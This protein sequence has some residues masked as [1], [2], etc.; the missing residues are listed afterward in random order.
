[1]FK[2]KNALSFYRS[3]SFWVS[4]KSI[5]SGPNDFGHVQIRFLLTNFYY[6]DLFSNA[7]SLYGSKMILNKKEGPILYHLVLQAPQLK[8]GGVHVAGVVPVHGLMPLP[9]MQASD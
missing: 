7:L 4:S 2:R 3:K 1:V 6:L 9:L 8:Q 5:W